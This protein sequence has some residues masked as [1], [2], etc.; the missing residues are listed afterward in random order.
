MKD[1][2]HVIVTGGHGFIGRRLINALLADNIAVTIIEH[3]SSPAPPDLRYI[4]TI[5]VDITNADDMRCVELDEAQAVLHLAGQS[6]GPRSFEE[7]ELDIRLNILG[8]LNVIDA[9]RKNNIPEVIFASSFVIYGDISGEGGVPEDTIANPKSVYATSKHACELLLKNYAEPHNIRWKAMRMFNVYGPGQ[10][11]ERSDQGIAGIFMRMVRDEDVIEVKGAL[12]RF[13]D[14]VYID[15]VV[16]AWMAAL[17]WDGGN[18]ALNVCSGTKTTI[19]E[20]INELI[21][22]SKRPIAPEIRE[23]GATPGDIMGCF[24]SLDRSEQTTGYKPLTPLRQGLEE[25][26]DACVTGDVK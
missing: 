2:T 18:Q 10:N 6:S 5:Y 11:I 9:C 15:D 21:A 22:V 13:R 17:R 8:T 14:L 23:V 24:G 16:N 12:N 19:E 4:P 1:L 3:P 20:L 26:W 7:P 25:M